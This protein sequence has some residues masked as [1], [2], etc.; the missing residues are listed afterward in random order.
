L[1][2]HSQVATTARYAHLYPD[3]Q[4]VAV[5]RVGARISGNVEGPGGEVIPLKERKA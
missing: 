3:A 4:R 1:L 2:G 5:E